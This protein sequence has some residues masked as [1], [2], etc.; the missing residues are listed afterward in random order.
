MLFQ[1]QD[2][3][4]TQI[5]TSFPAG[6][7]QTI[8]KRIL[9][10]S[11][12]VP[13]PMPSCLKSTRHKHEFHRIHYYFLPQWSYPLFL[14]SWWD[15]FLTNRTAQNGKQSCEVGVLCTIL[16]QRWSQ[17]DW[18]DSIGVM[19]VGNIVAIVAVQVHRADPSNYRQQPT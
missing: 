11:D 17:E 15:S 10:S 2:D 13:G 14:G 9:H 8:R 18:L 3:L 5:K 7:P 1:K 16:R 12:V 4:E 19:A 6:N